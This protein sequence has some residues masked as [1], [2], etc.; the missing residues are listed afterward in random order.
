MNVIETRLPG[1]L[2]LEPRSFRDDRGHFAETWQRERY[3]EA[4]IEGDFVQ[5]NLSFS[6]HGVL[7]GLHFQ[8]PL[9]QGKLVSVLQGEVW[10]VA[11]DVR[12]DSPTFAQWVGVELSGSSLRQLWIPEGFAH[13]F[14]VTGDMALFSY[15]CTNPYSPE[16]ERSLRWDDPYVGIDWPIPDPVLSEKDA[17]APTL[18]ELSGE[19]LFGRL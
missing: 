19:V 17:Q 6:R 14:V 2:I 16:F 13:G 8:N 10:D 3:R 7:R 5:D 1:V 4:G 12:R 15:K 18:R 9:P 11:V